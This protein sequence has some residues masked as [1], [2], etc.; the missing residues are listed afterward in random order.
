MACLSPWSASFMT[1]A[2]KPIPAITRNGSRP[3][4]GRAS[5][6]MSAI[7]A[8]S[9]SVGSGAPILPTSIRCGLPVKATMAR[10]LSEEPSGRLRLRASRF[11]VPSGRMPSGTSVPASCPATVRTVPSPPAA[12]TTAGPSAKAARVW[13]APG[14]SGVVPY[15]RVAE[16]PASAA[17]CSTTALR[18]LMSPIFVGLTT[19]ATVLSPVSAFFCGRIPVAAALAWTSRLLRAPIEARLCSERPRAARASASISHQCHVML[20]G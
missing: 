10:L 19:T 7:C 20:Q 13:P 12:I 18:S 15:Q 2:S 14:S 1:S 4:K 11:P 16:Y 3:T 8:S 9:P 6:P 5:G 17:A